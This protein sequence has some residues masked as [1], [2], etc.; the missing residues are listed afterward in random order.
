MKVLQRSCGPLASIFRES[1]GQGPG[2][3]G[4]LPSAGSVSCCRHGALAHV[5]DV[6][7]QPGRTPIL[8]GSV[9]QLLKDLVQAAAWPLRGQQHRQ[10]Q[11]P[12]GVWR[13]SQL[14]SMRFQPAAQ[15]RIAE[16]VAQQGN[17]PAA[18]RL[19]DRGG[20]S[21]RGTRE[22]SRR[23]GRGTGRFRRG[24]RPG[25]SPTRCSADVGPCRGCS[26]SA[27]SGRYRRLRGARAGG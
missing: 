13:P 25:R 19:G 6:R 26:A 14:R 23:T 11:Q 7:S 9:L 16:M 22:P 12:P 18:E 27:T 17:R 2:R 20:A 3:V 1:C 8:R 21:S 24:R 15:R 5:G 10:V 4:R